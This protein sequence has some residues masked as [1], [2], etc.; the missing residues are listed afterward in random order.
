MN[1]SV[2]NE[3]LWQSII[4]FFISLYTFVV[5]VSFSKTSP[6]TVIVQLFNS[7]IILICFIESIIVLIQIL[8]KNFNLGTYTN[9]NHL[10][11][12]LVIGILITID[13]I[14]NNFEL[15]SLILFLPLLLLF[16]IILSTTQSRSAVLCLIFGIIIIL[17]SK[18]RYYGLSAII[19]LVLSL[20]ILLP[21]KTIINLSKLNSN[22][23]YQ[24]ISY[25]I[26]LWNI[27]L[28]SVL[29]SPVIGNGV[30][31]YLHN[32]RLYRNPVRITNFN[33]TKYE[34]EKRYKHNMLL[35]LAVEHGIPT[36]VGVIITLFLF[37]CEDRKNYRYSVYKVLILCILIQS[38]VEFSLHSPSLL[39]LLLILIAIDL[40][41]SRD[42]DSF[43][44]S[45]RIINIVNILSLVFIILA[46][47]L[48]ISNY[49]AKKN[50][51]AI[52]T[53]FAPLNTEYRLQNGHEYIRTNKLDD[54]EK[55][56]KIAS[57]IDNKNPTYYRTLGLFYASNN[58]KRDIIESLK[59]YSYAISLH[60]YNPFYY[61]ELGEIYNSI[62]E[63]K[64]AV[65][66]YN[67]ALDLEPLYNIA[68]Y[69]IV[70]IS[71]D[72]SVIKKHSFALNY[73]FNNFL[74]NL[75]TSNVSEYQKK[76]LGITK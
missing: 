1:T 18:W 50:G 32:Y 11:I 33:P 56:Y 57:K 19:I 15:K 76:V 62:S 49:Y 6:K 30:E 59:N 74:I 16:L 54:A 75:D 10:A 67:K 36:A 53:K 40:I 26:E 43:K 28:K 60:P 7:V 73:F 61:Y 22:D 17:I 63:D 5:L 45:S 52:A 58:S 3:T 21:N 31:G 55:C 66:C 71:K 72:E 44:I 65:D 34:R 25:R 27:A 64:L 14:I 9:I 12:L 39:L 29:K 69:K 23:N 13:Y 37:F 35:Q 41:Q 46:G 20:F 47:C 4:L 51:F 70:K 38:L 48:L 8:N 24:E 42:S 68:R 2:Y